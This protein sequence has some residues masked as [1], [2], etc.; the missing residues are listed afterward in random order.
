MFTFR[1]RGVVKE[2]ESGIGVSGLFI[3]AYD[4]DLLFD[5]LMGS[6]YS[7]ENGR[8]EIVSLP[9]D[10][11]EFLDTKPDVYLQIYTPDGKSLLF[12]T[13]DAVRWQ[14]GE[15]EVFEVLIPRKHLGDLSPQRQVQLVDDRG[16]ER[17]D[18]DVGEA[19]TVRLAGL[20]PAVAYDVILKDESGEELF[21]SRLM[22]NREGVIDSAVL[23]PQFGLDDPHTGEALGIEEAQ[24]RW[25]GQ[26]LTMVVQTGEEVFFEHPVQVA[27]AFNRPILLS[28]DAHGRITNS[29]LAGE[30]DALVTG[31]NAP[32]EGQARVFMVP[33]QRDWLTG[34]SFEPVRLNSGRPAYVDVTVEDGHFL[35]RVAGADELAPSAYDFIV[36]PLRYGYEDD[37][38][39]V[40]RENDLVTR[41]VTGL[42]VQQAFMA[43]KAVLGGCVNTQPMSGQRISGKPYYQF[44]NTFQAGS[45]VWAALDPAALDP[46]L[47]GKAVALYVIQH[48]TPSDW[49]TGTNLNHLPILG[50]NP[51]VLKFKTQPGCINFNDQLVWANASITGEYD[52]VADFGNNAADLSTFAPDDSLDS[53]LDIIDGYFVS[54]FRVVNDPSTETQYSHSG[55][56]SYTESTEGSKTV[57]DDFG[58]LVIVPIRAEVRFPADAAGATLPSEISTTE[59]SYPMIVIVHGNGHNYTDYTYLLDHWAKNGFIAA[60]IHLKGNQTGTDRALILFEHLDILK[61]RFGTKAANNIGIMGHSRGGEA[62]VIA[63]RVNQQQGLGHNINAIISLAPTDQYT[64]ESMA[65]AWATPYLVIYGSMDGDVAGGWGNPWNTGF[66]LY[67]RAT[68]ATKS[69]VFVYGATHNRFRE[70]GQDADITEWWSSLGPS[71]MSRLISATAHQKIALGYMTA[72]FRQHL[73]NESEWEGILKGEWVP[74]AVEQADSGNV[75]L[76]IQFEGTNQE[77]VDN[78]EGPH[79]ATSWKKSTIGSAI[80]G[81]TVTH[82][83]TLPTDPQENDLYNLDNHSPHD[84]A[85]LLL[86]W[87]NSG[88]RLRFD[89]PATDKNVTIYDAVS[90]RITQKVGSTQNPAGAQDLYLTLKDTTGKSRSIKVSKFQEIPEPHPR[91]N[92]QYTKSA[93]STVRIPLH[94][95]EI[96][97]LGTDR[98]DLTEI[99]SVTFDFKVKPT[100]EV[101]IDSVAFTK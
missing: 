39:F 74:S 70:A 23:W 57:T 78:F 1:I 71:D 17:M 4:K 16:N 72:F 61:T 14:A 95:F 15:E 47:L 13:E 6:A 5:D 76:Y 90:F 75:K 82:E 25:R 54:G 43:S 27:G 65:G 91:H 3:R 28:T 36:R 41:A 7:G 18:F 29:F 24:E 87:D 22:S 66:A 19:L 20:Q 94:V 38:S 88:D 52:I 48:K 37:E 83:G 73:Q 35:A 92:A 49:S 30:R 26:R 45:D 9:G 89:I 62:V 86:R 60:S 10:F 31:Y 68:D 46:N 2:A 101:E 99:E 100:G 21:A 69:M 97:V 98:V 63:A 42:V 58:S 40:L 77:E 12:S 84:T 67:D 79:T 32:F 33:R 59:S 85:G 8:F 11:Q 64:D 56:F 81:D 55:G 93:M 80:A 50:G 44:S 53:P 96:E 51:A 34:D